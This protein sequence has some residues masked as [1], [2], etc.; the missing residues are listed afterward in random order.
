MQTSLDAAR[1]AAEQDRELALAR[2][3]RALIA[4]GAQRLPHARWSLLEH[5]AGTFRVLEQWEQPLPVCLAGLVHSVYTTDTYRRRVFHDDERDKLRSLVGERAEYLA[6][7][8]SRLDRRAL[9]NLAI[10]EHARGLDKY[11]LRDRLDGEDIQLFAEDVRD[12][13]VIHLANIVEQSARE[14]GAPEEWLAQA[15]RIAA[16]ANEFNCAP[17]VF[18]NCT[19][20]VSIEDERALLSSYDRSLAT[21]DENEI[22]SLRTACNKVP[23]V[24]EP[25]VW[26]GLCDL[27]RGDASSASKHGARAV[28]IICGWNG[29]WDK[30]L[31]ESQWLRLATFLQE[32]RD[33]QSRDVEFLR[34]RL[35]KILT[36]TA[37]R[38]AGVFSRL[39]AVGVLSH[40]MIASANDPDDVDPA[41]FDT[42]PPRF[43]DYVGGFRQNANRPRMGT[44]PDLES[45]RFWEAADFPLAAELE[46]SAQ[47][48]I[49]EF[50]G[51]PRAF[52]HT[53]SEKLERTG[54]W[55]VFLLY[56]RGR[57]RDDR[58]QLVPEAARIVQAH[59][60]MRTF[61]GLIY[62]SRMAPNTLIAPHRGPT[63]M[64]L[65]CHLGIDIPESCAIEVG[66]E[67]RAWETG[68]CL[69]FDDSFEHQA[70]NRSDKERIVLV[71]DLWHPDLSEDEVALLQGLDRHIS[72]VAEGLVQY[73][74]RNEAAETK[75]FDIGVH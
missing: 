39:E 62:F 9:F 44:Y 28:D 69:I 54:D 22:A 47:S 43:A 64:R 37:D 49:A 30:R 10:S 16:F 42:L 26:L 61:N 25:F 21:P 34:E 60:T 75:A 29:A 2:T 52:F 27:A 31:S 58:C 19:R 59:R 56:E 11:L 20:V 41:L 5:L 1:S 53:E 73:W 48:I 57:R 35:Q 70:W 7:L 63:N 40:D 33:L 4:R 55:D 65:R 50:Q 15:S 8:F 18:A 46:R 3:E 67:T 23:W 71:V 51:I 24:A 72:H 6:N 14:T 38:P 66:G 32:A 12:L 68:R 13:L 36:T 74:K 45:R 17:P